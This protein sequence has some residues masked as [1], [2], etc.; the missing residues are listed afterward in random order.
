MKEGEEDTLITG[1]IQAEKERF[2]AQQKYLQNRVSKA[3]KEA[4]RLTDEFLKIDPALEQVI[5][6]GSLAEDTVRSEKFDIDLAVKSEKYLQLVSLGLDSEFKV[7]I[8][9]LETLPNPFKNRIMEKG[10][11]LYDRHNA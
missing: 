3:W 6:F 10:R 1:I 11:I 5:M 8:V 9:E 2:A 7:D 4:R